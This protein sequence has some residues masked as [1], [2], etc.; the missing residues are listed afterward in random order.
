MLTEGNITLSNGTS[1]TIQTTLVSMPADGTAGATI[2]VPSSSGLTV[3][4][5]DSD[6][7]GL[8]G[9]GNGLMDTTFNVGQGSN[10]VLAGGT[11][12]GIT[13]FNVAE[14]ATIDLTGGQSTY[15]GNALTGSGSGTVQLTGGRFLPTLGGVTLN[16]PGN[17]FQWTGGAMF[18]GLG[19][20]TNEKTGTLNLAGSNDK[21]F[22]EDSTLD[23]FGTMIQTGTGNLALH[24]DNVIQTTLKIE[25]GASYLIESDSG[26]DNDYG[27]VTA[28]SQRGS[29]PQDGG[30]RHVTTINQRRPFKFQRPRHH[31]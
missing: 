11:Y 25:P 9:S 29:H 22:Y 15:Y 31:Q 13:T 6:T 18:A 14:T 24:S 21:G 26:I 8:T 19:D 4:L 17:M 12:T 10:V 30:H 3:T 16:F 20:V 5:K 23:N 28:V 2:N 1:V 27:G 7:S